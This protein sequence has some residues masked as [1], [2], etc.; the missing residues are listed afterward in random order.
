MKTLAADLQT[1]HS[2]AGAAATEVLAGIRTDPAVSDPSAPNAMRAA[3]TMPDP[4]DE[5]P[6]M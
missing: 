4:E 3:V 5:P 1:A 2:E 6:V